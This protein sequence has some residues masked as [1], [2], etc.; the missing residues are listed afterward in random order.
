MGC[1][2][3]EAM[4]RLA[5]LVRA[6]TESSVK[7]VQPSVPIVNSWPS[8]VMSCNP[9]SKHEFTEFMQIVGSCLR[10]LGVF[11]LDPSA[12]HDPRGR[13]YFGEIT[14]DRI[15]SSLTDPPKISQISNHLQ[16]CGM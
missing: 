9:L 1:L 15:S 6:F 2:S 10:A 12:L 11:P 4:S 8:S 5:R 16:I 13:S 3:R 14:L 7:N